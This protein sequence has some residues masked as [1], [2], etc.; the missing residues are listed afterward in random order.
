MPRDSAVNRDLHGEAVEW[1][2]STHLLAALV[3]HAAVSN[4]M[5]ATINSGEDAEPLDYPEPVPRPN[6][7]AAEPD[8]DDADSGGGQDDELPAPGQLARFFA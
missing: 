4:W 2:A 3:D 6:L 1:D 8:T 7:S 5:T